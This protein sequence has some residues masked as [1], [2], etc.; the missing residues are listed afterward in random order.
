MTQDEIRSII[1]DY[2]LKLVVPTATVI[3]IVAGIAGYFVTNAAVKDAK[4]S[5]LMEFLSPIIEA[6]N[7]AHTAAIGAQSAASEVESALKQMED[8][9]ERSRDAVSDAERATKSAKAILKDISDGFEKDTISSAVTQL[10]ALIVN[11]PAFQNRL[12]GDWFPN[13]SYL[14]VAQDDDCP[15]TWTKMGGV[16]TYI[17]KDDFKKFSVR[18]YH[19]DSSKGEK[20]YET[21]RLYLCQKR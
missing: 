2:L 20:G 18:D 1:R 13:R 11:D 16:L 7:D 15:P 12:V 17:Q 3:G 21:V 19:Y 4:A 14:V 6:S 10:Q 5:A 8:N 9:V